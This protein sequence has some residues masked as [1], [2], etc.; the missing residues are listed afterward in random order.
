ML[1]ILWI[2]N[3]PCGAAKK[4][5]GKGNIGGGWLTS[6]EHELNRIMI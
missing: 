4:E 5:Y 1:K 3:T 6:L 2:T